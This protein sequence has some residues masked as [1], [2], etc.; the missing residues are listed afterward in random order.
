MGLALMTAVVFSCLRCFFGVFCP[1]TELLLWASQH[2]QQIQPFQTTAVIKAK[3][4]L[5]TNKLLQTPA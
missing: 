3:P 2:H 4:C 5:Q 1:W